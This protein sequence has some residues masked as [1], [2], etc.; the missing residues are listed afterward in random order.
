VK[1]IRWF[2]AKFGS[3]A[4]SSRPMSLAPG[5]MSSATPASGFESTPFVLRMRMLPGSLSVMSSFPSGRKA[6]HQGAGILSSNVVT[7]NAPDE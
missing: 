2:A 5:D 4:T 3:S 7:R 1:K 6:T